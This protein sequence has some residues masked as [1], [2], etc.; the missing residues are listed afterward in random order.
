MPKMTLKSINSQIKALEKKK[1]ALEQAE[2]AGIAQ[3]KAVVSKYKLTRQDVLSALGGALKG[4]KVAPKY[5]NPDN[6]NDTWTGRGRQPKWVVA[7]L[8]AGKKLDDM[9]I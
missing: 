2:K 6:K 8:K 7:K 1:A 9:K 3:L 4:R 5:R